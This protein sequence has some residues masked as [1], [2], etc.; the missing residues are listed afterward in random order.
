[1]LYQLSYFA[2]AREGSATVGTRALPAR[3]PRVRRAGSALPLLAALV[4]VL[5]GCGKKE[6]KVVI[7]DPVAEALAHAPADAAALAVVATDTKGG[8]AA[9]LEALAERFSGG[10]LVLGQ[11]ESALARRLGLDPGALR[12]LR[13]NPLVAWSPDGS[14]TRLF[15]AWVTRDAKRTGQLVDAQEDD[16][17]LEGAPGVGDYALYTRRGGGALARR[18]PLLVTAPDLAALRE[19]LRRRAAGRGQWTRALLGQRELGLPA[20]GASVRVAL[21][22]HRVLAPRAGRAARTRWVA[23]LRRGALVAT[24]V[25]GGLRVHAR[26]STAPSGLTAADLPLSTGVAPPATRGRAPILAAVRG[27]QPALRFARRVTDLLS[28][29][30]LDGLRRA[31]ELLR[32]YA[33]VDLQEDVLDRLS[34][35]ATLTTRDGR[36]GTLRS[37]LDDPGRV[38][39]A[40]GRIGTLARFGGPLAQLAGVD[41]GG[42]DV[43]ERDGR[44]VLTQDGVLLVALKLVDG[45]L[46]ASTEPGADLDAAGRAPAAPRPAPTAGS[47]RATVAADLVRQRIADRLGLPGLVR[48]ALGPLG[49]PVLTARA[50]LDHLDVQLVVPIAR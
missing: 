32:R 23:A 15:A 7:A 40:L 44:Y 10:D 30:R 43:E 41:L 27:P 28:P 29:R 48:T 8:P 11:G 2:V 47:F 37:D 12:S 5:G 4:V 6:D 19:V 24:P 14:T 1:M 26:V 33:R 16:G 9:A 38:A 13:G 49:D 46:V 36:V 25:G 34:G 21:D 50:E 45:A 39:D 18:G 42:F 20:E 22:A 3:V 17:A 35:T 31:E